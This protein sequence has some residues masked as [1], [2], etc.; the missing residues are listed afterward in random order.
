MHTLGN[1]TLTAFNGTLSN[2]PF[3]RKRQ[4]YGGS[5]LQ[6]NHA[7]AA[8]DAWGREEILAR[9]DELAG[10]RNRRSGQA[11]CRT[12]PRSPAGF[13]WSQI[14]AA[15]ATIPP[16]SWTTYGDLAQLGGTAAMPV[17]QHVANTPGLDN[18]YRVLGSDG[19]P[20]PDFHW[21]S[22]D[23]M[24]DV[25][26]VLTE[27]G[28]RFQVNGAAEMSQRIT[29]AELSSLIDVLDDDAIE[30]EAAARPPSSWDNRSGTGTDTASRWGCPMTGS[31]SD[32]SW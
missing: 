12:R 11:R 13:D 27:D 23:D 2:N 31:P 9:A 26:S 15:I 20:R 7:L 16:G 4:I 24:R 10:P 22:P 21:D 28:V 5:N 19:R 17:G 6:L 14:N 18:G 30:A 3:E 32:A 8:N 29:A 1:L 25:I